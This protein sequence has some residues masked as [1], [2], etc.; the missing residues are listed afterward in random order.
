MYAYIIKQMSEKIKQLCQNG[1]QAKSVFPFFENKKPD[2][3]F[4]NDRASESPSLPPGF[5]GIILSMAANPVVS[6]ISVTI[7]LA[8]FTVI[9]PSSPMTSFTIRSVRSPAEEM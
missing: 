6:K 8:P 9:T 5:Y 7:G 2:R 3:L 1:Q 4:L